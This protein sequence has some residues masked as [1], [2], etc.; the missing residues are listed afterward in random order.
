MDNPFTNMIK[1][2]MEQQFSFFKNSFPPTTFNPLG[3]EMHFRWTDFFG[4]YK[5]WFQQRD[6]I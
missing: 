1:T 6:K 3:Y 5:I 4:G 2:T